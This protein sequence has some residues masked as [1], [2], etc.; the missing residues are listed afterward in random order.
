MLWPIKKD[1]TPILHVEDFRTEDG[2]ATFAYHQYQL[3][4]QVKKLVNN[5][6]FAKAKEDQDIVKFI[7][8]RE[9]IIAISHLYCKL[10]KKRVRL[11]KQ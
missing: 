1:D 6:E 2:K 9:A 4:E 11:K 8:E 5:E 3:R 10:I 7:V